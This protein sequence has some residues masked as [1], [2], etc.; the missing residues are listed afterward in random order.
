MTSEGN[1]ALLRLDPLLCSGLRARAMAR[2]NVIVAAK[3]VKKI[4]AKEAG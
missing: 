4:V 3:K 2:N 1:Q